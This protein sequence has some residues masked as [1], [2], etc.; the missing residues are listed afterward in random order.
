[1]VVVKHSTNI[2]SCVSFEHTET[3]LCLILAGSIVLLQFVWN[4]I[5]LLDLTVCVHMR[6]EHDKK[7]GDWH[8]LTSKDWYNKPPTR[9]SKE[10]NRKMP[11]AQRAKAKKEKKRDGREIRRRGER[12]AREER[13]GGNAQTSHIN[14]SILCRSQVISTAGWMADRGSTY[15]GQT[16]TRRHHHRQLAFA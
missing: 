13:K 4:V 12:M 9:H 2:R 14:I 7:R 6:A 8:L 10:V 11:N 5:F 3:V 15:L 16:S 1:M